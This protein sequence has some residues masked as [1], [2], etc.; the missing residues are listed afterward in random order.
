VCIVNS[1]GFDSIPSD[2]GSLFVTKYMKQRYNQRCSSIKLY[3][4]VLKGDASGGTLASAIAAFDNPE[5]LSKENRNPYSLEDLSSWSNASKVEAITP[6]RQH[7]QVWVKY[8]EDVKRWTCPW[9][10]SSTNSKLVRRSNSLLAY[11][12]GP[13]LE[14]SETMEKKSYLSAVVF[15]LILLGLLVSLYFRVT[16]FFAQKFLPAPGEGPS[17]EKM[18]AGFLK[19]TLVA[20]GETDKSKKVTAVLSLPKDPGYMF[21]SVMLAESALCLALQREQLNEAYTQRRK[22]YDSQLLGGILTPASAM[23]EILLDRLTRVGF[24]INVVD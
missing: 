10:M 22:D 16:R 6:P 20:H 1:C 24:K 21:T 23:G 3:I 15:N 2:L 7:E 11:Q 18:N 12:F 5:A 17:R 8:D 14:Y 4:N 9:M 19:A 13:S